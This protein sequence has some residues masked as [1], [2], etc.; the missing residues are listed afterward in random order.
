MK[1]IDLLPVSEAVKN[2]I[3]KTDSAYRKMIKVGAD[4]LEV[5]GD[6]ATIRIEQFDVTGSDPLSPKELI[7]KGKEVFSHAG[8]AI[9]IQWRPLVFKGKELDA[10]G[11]D[12]VRSQM[13]KKGI[14]QQQLADDLG[15]DRHVMSKLMSG[16]FE[17]TKWHRAAFWY[18]FKD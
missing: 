18:Y 7:H 6:T 11:P 15:V 8:D 1:N 4:V 5:H 9:K 13:K 17:F 3:Q 12:W 16:K 14:N 10:V 2:A